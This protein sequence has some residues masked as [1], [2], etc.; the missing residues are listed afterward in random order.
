MLLA[1]G[2]HYR[3][4]DLLHVGLLVS[5]G[6]VLRMCGISHNF[7]VLHNLLVIT[8]VG[9]RSLVCT[10]AVSA[11]VVNQITDYINQNGIVYPCATK[12]PLVSVCSF[13]SISTC[14][15]VCVSVAACLSVSD[16]VVYMTSSPPSVHVHFFYSLII[17]S[18]IFYYFH[19]NNLM[20]FTVADRNAI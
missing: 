19:L 18:H 1:H 12:F 14:L 15:S 4:I 7:H 6:F 16:W 2:Q 20:Q 11:T 3:K 10:L 17:F 9:V 5:A 13:V 8:A